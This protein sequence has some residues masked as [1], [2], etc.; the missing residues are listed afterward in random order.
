MA[1]IKQLLDSAIKNG[2]KFG[3]PDEASGVSITSITQGEW[4]QTYTAPDDGFIFLVAYNPHNLFLSTT[5]GLAAYAQGIANS[6]GSQSYGSCMLPVRKG[7]AYTVFFDK[8]EGATC[9]LAF[10][11]LRGK[12]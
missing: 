10:F 11:P 8:A 12:T 2:G 1:S 5:W 7:M 4:G 3:T 6:K 9:H